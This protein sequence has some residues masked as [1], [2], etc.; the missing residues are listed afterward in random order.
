MI[1]FLYG[2]DT[3]RSRAKV[4]EIIGEF[5]KKAGGVLNVTRIDAGDN[6][7]AALMAGRTAPLFAEKELVVIERAS[8]SAPEV[9]RHIRDRLPAWKSDRNLTIIFWEAEV[10]EDET[11]VKE[12]KE[13]AAKTQEFKVLAPAALREWLVKESDRRGARI[14]S[15]ETRL[16]I[17]RY[18]PD[19][20]ALANELDKI[21]A[22]WLASAEITAEEKIWNFTDMFF[23]DRRRSIRPLAN[24]L[25]SGYEP[26][27]II[28][29]LAAGLRTISFLWQGIARGTL[30]T[31]AHGLHPFAAKKNAEIA[32]SVDAQTLRELFERLVAADVALKTGRLPS[33]LPLI[34]LVVRQ[35]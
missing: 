35:R 17:A 3:Y 1:Y 15:D 6:P 7:E 34:D 5:R 13:H 8:E 12:I 14:G 19:L 10:S 18:G 20:W 23:K 27:Q 30:D 21:A 32:R 11:I 4:R 25:A 26:I 9:R 16:L 29:A 24:L 28:G 22:G 31:S 2:P 33:P